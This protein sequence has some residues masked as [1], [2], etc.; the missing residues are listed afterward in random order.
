MM[1]V[2]T[3]DL[4][5]SSPV[6]VSLSSPQ[7]LPLNELKHLIAPLSP[8]HLSSSSSPLSSTRSTAAVLPPPP[9]PRAAAVQLRRHLPHRQTPTF[10]V[11]Y[12]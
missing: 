5:I 9:G 7:R 10:Y 3:L 4:N 8:L 11:K 1:E 2:G 12:G 6:S